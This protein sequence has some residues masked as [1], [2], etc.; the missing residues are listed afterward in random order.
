[1][2]CIDNFLGKNLGWVILF[3]SFIDSIRFFRVCRIFRELNVE[4]DLIF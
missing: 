3:G 1:M 2:S 4:I